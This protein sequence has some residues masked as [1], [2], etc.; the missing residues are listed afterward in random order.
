MEDVVRCGV[1]T[2]TAIALLI[3]ERY[4]IDVTPV[5]A[6][7]AVGRPA[8]AEEARGIAISAMAEILHARDAGAREPRGACGAAGAARRCSPEGRR[9]RAP[10]A[11]RAGRNARSRRP[12]P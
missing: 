2:W 6:L 12:R 4:G 7:L 5:V 8:V 3:C 9:A 11:A 10:A 1:Q